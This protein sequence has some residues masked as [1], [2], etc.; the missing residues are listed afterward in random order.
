MSK[1]SYYPE[2]EQGDWPRGDR[3]LVLGLRI[4]R[5]FPTGRV[6]TQIRAVGDA[7]ALGAILGKVEGNYVA[8]L[9]S[10]IDANA[11]APV[12]HIALEAFDGTDGVDVSVKKIDRATRLVGQIATGSATE[13]DI[14]R[15]G[16]IVGDPTT[17]LYVVNL[18]DTEVPS[19]EVTS[20]EPLDYPWEDGATGD[21][22]LVEFRFLET[23]L[24]IAP[25]TV[26]S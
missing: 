16:R 23:V 25:A 2:T 14:H 26:G 1:E 11:S 12:S 5:E 13:D 20:V 18:D 10:P 7:F 17:G 6:P 19:I 9:P 21:H 24:A 4:V 15:R 22:N 8:A 3:D